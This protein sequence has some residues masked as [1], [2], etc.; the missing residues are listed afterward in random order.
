MQEETR[1]SGKLNSLLKHKNKFET[2]IQQSKQNLPPKQQ[3]QEI[4]LNDEN[5]RDFT[6][7]IRARPLLEHE[8]SSNYFSVVTGNNPNMIFHEAKLNVQ[9]TPIVQDQTF[10]VDFAF[11]E[12]DNNDTVYSVTGRPLVK[13][14][15]QGGLGAIFAYG[16]TGSGKTYTMQGVCQRIAQ[17]IFKYNNNGQKIYVGFFELLGNKAMDLVDQNRKIDILEDKFGKVQANGLLETEVTSGNQ[18]QDLVIQAQANRKTQA[19]FKNDVSSRTH[20]ICQIR[21]ENPNQLDA[22]NGFIYII[23]L[24][25]SENASDQQFHNKQQLAETKDINKSL[26]ALK[27]CIRNRALASVEEKFI[28]VPFRNSKLT[29]LL[30]DSFDLYSFKKTKTVVIANIAPAIADLQ[31]TLNTLRYTAPIRVTTKSKKKIEINPNNPQFWDNNKLRKYIKFIT[32]KYNSKVE[33]DLD[34]FC[35]YESGKQMLQLHQEKFLQ[36][37]IDQGYP[38]RTAE[39]VYDAFYK[40]FID[41]RFADIKRIQD[42]AGQ[43]VQPEMDFKP[44]GVRKRSAGKQL[45]KQNNQQNT[46][47][48]GSLGVKNKISLQQQKFQKQKQDQEQFLEQMRINKNQENQKNEIENNNLVPNSQQFSKNQDLNSLLKQKQQQHLTRIQ[49][50]FSNQNQIQNQNQNQNLPPQPPKQQPFQNQNQIPKL[51][52]QQN[53]PNNNKINYNKNFGNDTGNQINSNKYGDNQ[54]NFTYHSDN[55]I[56]Q[57]NAQQQDNNN[58]QQQ[59]PNLVSYQQKRQSLKLQQQQLYD[60]QNQNYQQQ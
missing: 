39:F 40:K 46:S 34:K 57:R 59:Q 22:E 47:S 55:L 26:M 54:E 11:G 31:Q 29:L 50:K 15:L 41:N 43:L 33:I 45:N 4:D 16:Q 10:P 49:N 48:Q 58:Y 18:F 14:A 12:E 38:K 52:N 19:T 42:Q 17:D 32:N 30:K 3:F 1:I 7:C 9:Q 60:Q 37:L 56:K 36:R 25:G 5:D 44:N 23:D 2:Q 53:S 27:E 6:I 24:V 21:V 20:S 13:L 8:Q 51:F 35:P 28:H